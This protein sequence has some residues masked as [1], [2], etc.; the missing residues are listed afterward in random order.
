MK[1]WIAEKPAVGKLI[2]E[3]LGGGKPKNGYI[4]CGENIVTWCFGHLIRSV[5][6]EDYDSSYKEW[7]LSTLPMRMYPLKYKPI[8]DK[9]DQV[10]LIGHL[11]KKADCVVNGG[12][13]DDE[14]QLLV[15]ELLIYHHYKGKVERVLISD[16]N[17]NAV[18]KSCANLQD[19][20][21]FKG[22][23]L[24]AY[25][26]ASGDMIYGL[27]LSRALT[28]NARKNGY[29]GSV[30]TLGR[31][32]TP[33]L[34]LVVDRFLKN[35]NHESSF[36]YELVCKAG[37][38]KATAIFEADEGVAKDENGRIVNNILLTGIASTLKNS[39]EGTVSFFERKE[40]SERP[41]LPYNLAKLQQDM[42]KKFKFTADETLKITQE[43]REKFKAI[44]YNRSDCSYLSDEQFLES[45]KLISQIKSIERYSKI[46]TNASLKSKA[47]DS[48]KITAH[49]AI[50]PTGTISGVSE[51]TESQ[52]NVYFAICDLYLVQFL[53]E[54]KSETITMKI[55]VNGHQFKV[56]ET[57]IIDF[58]F[59]SFLGS[60]DEKDNAIF[61][62]LSTFKINDR[63]SVSDFEVLSKKTTPPKL[64]TEATLIG[65]MTRIADYVEDEKIRKLLKEKDKDS[66]DENG[67]IGTPATR[68]S[69]IERLK[70]SNFIT[71][72]KNNL[73][74]TSNAIE[75]VNMLP[76]SIT[77][78][79]M[80]ALWFEQ[81]IDISE[82]KISVD[83]FISSLYSDVEKL[84]KDVSNVD[85]SKIKGGAT[86]EEVGKCPNC[87]H[88]V[89][90]KKKVAE[91]SS[92][93]GFLLWRDKFGKN[94]TK[95]EITKLIVNG[96]TNLIKGFKS[97]AGKD[98]SAMLVLDG[99]LGNVK[100]E[101]ENKKG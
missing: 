40:K 93:C 55:D 29:D 42:N 101:F 60:S 19:N 74:P 64:F 45:E 98:F 13:I 33:T 48:A 56:T 61:D 3:A 86:F 66:K 22:Q 20:A 2:A 30:L 73:V 15:D 82:N 67:S 87:E 88:P 14:G 59:S 32:Q 79:D 21:L 65:A 50:I 91:C 100:L 78:P 83:A 36:F 34:S 94:L 17:I 23:Y 49:T 25:S 16:M 84:I 24:K 7:D 54:K 90:L 26:R 4:D 77:K 46:D 18:K 58:G 62:A 51:M 35:K 9:K 72:E 97:K 99:K 11:L 39:T 8:E 57:K 38:K 92:K 85:F 5:D 75:L 44:T 70:K 53:P 31:V 95:S 10:E 63:I 28:I 76:T 12:D 6:P 96:K 69:I 52:K 1:L 68:S 43:L 37:E 41:P 27:N 81:Q 47:F 71:V 80:T 89:F